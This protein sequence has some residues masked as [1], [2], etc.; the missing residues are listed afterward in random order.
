MHGTYRIQPGDTLWALSRR[1]GTTVKALAEANGIE[2]PNLIIAGRTLRLPGQHDEVDATPTKGATPKSAST[3]RPTRAKAPPRN[4][5]SAEQPSKVKLGEVPRGQAAQYAYFQQLVKASGGKFKT[6]ANQFNL[7]GLRTNTPTTANGGNGSYDDRLAVVWKDS[8]GRPHV[9]LLRYNTEP[10]RRMA[11]ASADVNGDG[12]ADQGRLVPGYYEYAK[13]SWKNGF[14]LRPVRDSQV[15]RDMDHDGRWDDAK[16]TGGGASMLF[17]GGGTSGTF[18]AGCQ[19]FPPSEWSR[20]LRLI[21]PA[22]GAFGY[23]LVT[24]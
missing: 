12:R 23:T 16:R 17:H 10:A 4:P 15:Q 11:Y 24:R 13:S 8:A 7:V 14:C 3:K 18:S 6:G 22:R 2:N 19:T 20:F 9:Q 1:F 5:A 21:G